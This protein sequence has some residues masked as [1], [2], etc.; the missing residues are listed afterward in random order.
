MREINIK[1]FFI[2]SFLLTIY[3]F[4]DIGIWADEIYWIRETPTLYPIELIATPIGHYLYMLPLELSDFN[5]TWIIDILHIL[6]INISIYLIYKYLELYHSKYLSFLL[7]FFIVVSFIYDGS[8]FW[9]LGTYIILSF[10]FMAYS[11]Y[12]IKIDNIRLGLIFG[13]LGS[14]AS[15]SSPIVTAGL[16]IGFLIKKDIKKFLIYVFPNFLYVVYYL[17]VTKYLDI[18][19]SRVHVEDIDVLKQF[20]LQIA[21]F[22]DSVTIGIFFKLFYLLKS[23]PLEYY[24]VSAILSYII[25]KYISFKEKINRELLIS[26]FVML[27]FGFIVLALSGGYY[28]T[29]F[30]LS[31]RVSFFSMVF[32]VYILI[33]LNYNKFLKIGVIFIFISSI[34]SISI[35]WKEWSLYSVSKSKDIVKEAKSKNLKELYIY[36]MGSSRLGKLSH[37]NLSIGNNNSYGDLK[38]KILNHVYFYKDGFIIKKEGGEKIKI[39]KY[40]YVYF[41]DTNQLKKVKRE[42]IN[43]LIEK[44]RHS[45]RHWSQ[46]LDSSSSIKSI[47]YKLMPSLKYER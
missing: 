42:D 11:F 43:S 21:T 12:L 38:I 30:T 4:W 37:L 10:A 20:I 34:F 7:S 33:A 1:Y 5:T 35:H 47:A 32:L 9:F 25:F 26:L 2:F 45:Y 18:G 14:F 36:D 28:Q 40:I 39:G 46:T 23:L 31:D 27:L 15:Y 24:I 13:F 44:S 16:S 17:F 19:V 22:I 41:L 29:I 3:L 6:Y 8:S